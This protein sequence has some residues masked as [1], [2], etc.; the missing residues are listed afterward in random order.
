MKA[1]FEPLYVAYLVYFNR[2]RDYFECHEVLEELWLEKE[3]EPVYQGLLQIAVALFH[4][5]N[6]TVNHTYNKIV[7][8]IKMMKSSYRKLLPYQHHA[9][10]INMEKLMADVRLYI[11]R[12]EHYQEQTFDF[13]DLNI[14][15]TDPLLQ[16]EVAQ[17]YQTIQ[18][19]LPMRMGYE[20]G[21]KSKEL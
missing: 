10:G 5:R 3:R 2:D 9:L 7:G 1:N 19:N 20:R 18:P 12:L 8:A 21:P 15:I 14:E 11:E 16:K 4:F 13:Y 17:A 6:G